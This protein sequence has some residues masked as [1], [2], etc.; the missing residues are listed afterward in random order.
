MHYLLPDMIG[1]LHKYDEDVLFK[2]EFFEKRMSKASQHEF[3]QIK[4][5]ARFKDNVQLGYNVGTR[6]NGVDK[7]KWPSD[8]NVE[9][10]T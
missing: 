8:L 10:V 2:P 6:T 5:V 4:P 7:P 3:V 9:I 1:R